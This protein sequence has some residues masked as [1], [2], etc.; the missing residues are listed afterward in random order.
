METEPRKY[1][2]PNGD[3]IRILSVGR[4]HWVK[5]YQYAVDTCYLLKEQGV[6]FEYCIIGGA[7]SE[8]LEYQVDALGLKENIR[9]LSGVPYSK[10]IEQYKQSD[11][12]LLPSVAEGIANVAL[13]AMALNVPVVT[14][15]CGGMEEVIT[16]GV[17]GFVVPIRD[18]KAMAK[19]IQKVIQLNDEQWNKMVNNA[20]LIVKQNHNLENQIE[21]MLEFYDEVYALNKE[22]RVCI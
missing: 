9:L 14:A 15:A 5:G 19:G 10:M 12:L 16:D 8:E 17:N 6:S 3:K 7:G 1:K 22:E 21:R 2:S 20:R 4:D 13:E 11:V 18:A